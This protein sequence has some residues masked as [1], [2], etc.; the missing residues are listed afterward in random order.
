VHFQDPDARRQLANERFADLAQEARRL[1]A[2]T[3]DTKAANRSML[4]AWLL[5][6]GEA[7]ARATAVASVRVP[8]MRTRSIA[9]A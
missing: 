2:S 5:L 9:R 7:V 6:A 1:P 3:A 4:T 8:R